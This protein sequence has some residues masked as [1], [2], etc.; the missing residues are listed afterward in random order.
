MALPLLGL[1]R[2]QL[3]PRILWCCSCSLVFGGVALVAVVVQHHKGCV[4]V[5]H[6]AGAH[7]DARYIGE[8]RAKV[9]QAREAQSGEVQVLLN[10]DV[11]IGVQTAYTGAIHSSL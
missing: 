1:C 8:Q 7:L 9:C 3:L 5:T 6:N 11:Y 2:V 10:G 4:T